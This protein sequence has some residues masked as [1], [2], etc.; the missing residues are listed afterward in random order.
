MKGKHFS[1]ETIIKLQTSHCH[2]WG[3]PRKKESQETRHRKSVLALALWKNPE[4]AKRMFELMNITPNKSELRLLF[5][6]N[7]RFGDEWHFVGDGQVWIAG[8]CPDFYRKSKRQIIELC[9]EHRHND[10]E[11]A[12]RIEFFKKYNFSVLIIWYKDFAASEKETLN[13]V[14]AFMEEVEE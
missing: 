11:T 3:H 12:D 4:H 6:L 7:E 2:P 10:L 8:K 1:P 14:A 13:K 9:G 5:L